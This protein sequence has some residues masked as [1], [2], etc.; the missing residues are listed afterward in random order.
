MATKVFSISIFKWLPEQPVFLVSA[1][2]L[3]SFGFFQKTSTK[4]FI[5][6]FSRTLIQ[7]TPVGKRQSVEHDEY[8]VHCYLRSDG[9]GGV[10][11]SVREYSE[12]VAFTLLTQ[13]LDK[14]LIQYGEIPSI[15]VDAAMTFDP[16]NEAIVKYQNPTEADKIESIKKELD[17]TM[18]I[19]HKTIDSVLDRGDKLNDLV[20]KSADLS[21]QSQLFYNTAAKQNSCCVIM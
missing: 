19:I 4:E 5:R 3:S 10:V 14:F 1:Y 2:D 18:D 9:I 7:R 6:F 16:I 21:K 20:N 15:N 8:M 11:V 17:E 12:R 13:L